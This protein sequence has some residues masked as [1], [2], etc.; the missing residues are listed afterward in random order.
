MIYLLTESMGFQFPIKEKIPVSSFRRPG[1]A[2]M[3]PLMLLKSDWHRKYFLLPHSQVYRFSIRRNPRPYKSITFMSWNKTNKLVILIVS[4]SC[5]KDYLE[6]QKIIKKLSLLFFLARKN[7]K[8]L[9]FIKF[10]EET[11]HQKSLSLYC[12]L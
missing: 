1:W 2:N 8:V 4:K 5:Q 6:Q 9:N 12:C 10:L 11:N 3:V 7:I